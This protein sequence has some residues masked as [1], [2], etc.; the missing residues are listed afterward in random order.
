[1]LIGRMAPEQN[2]YIQYIMKYV[3]IYKYVTIVEHM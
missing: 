3:F 2:F 1:M